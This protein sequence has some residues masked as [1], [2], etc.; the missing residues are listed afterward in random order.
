MSQ[1]WLGATIAGALAAATALTLGAGTA[2]AGCVQAGTDKSA[3]LHTIPGY[4]VAGMQ[5]KI[6]L[7]SPGPSNASKSI[8]GTWLVTYTSSGQPFGQAFIQWHDDGTEW[9]NIN[10]PVESGNICVGS[11]ASVDPTTVTRFHVGW[12]YTAGLLSGYFTETERDRVRPNTY[13][14][15]N[16]TTIFDLSGNVIV[17]VTGT[18]SAVRIGP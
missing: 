2:R 10:L 4:L 5:P 9:E 15:T 12:L 11:W 6:S 3:A 1:N 17:T 16:E 14:G 7:P 18:S 13:S 8:V